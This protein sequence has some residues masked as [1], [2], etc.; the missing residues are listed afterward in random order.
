MSK[1]TAVLSSNEHC[2]HVRKQ[3]NEN[4]LVKWEAKQF[5]WKGKKDSGWADFSRLMDLEDRI[6]TLKALSDAG[7][8]IWSYF[9]YKI[10]V[11]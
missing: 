2:G 8:F 4:S 5:G 7:S 10:S 11:L 3:Q 9:M 6:T 1:T